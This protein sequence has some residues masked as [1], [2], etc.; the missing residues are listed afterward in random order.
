VHRIDLARRERTVR[1]R[2]PVTTAARTLVDLAGSL[3]RTTLADAVDTAFGTGIVTPAAVCDAA[4]LSSRAPGKKGLP[5]LAKVLEPWIDPIRPDSPAEARLL[6]RLQEWGVPTPVR[7]HVVRD[8]AGVP[9]GPPAQAGLLLPE[10]GTLVPQAAAAADLPQQLPCRLARW[11]RRHRLQRAD[12]S[13]YA[14]CHPS[15]RGE[16]RITRRWR[17][18][19]L[20]RAPPGARPILRR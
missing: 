5:S 1:G 14:A 6:R 12:H 11:C 13:S 2:I 9:A 15:Q 3:P 20:L 18:T 4:R 17:S 7:Q 19:S 8:A 16:R 10:V